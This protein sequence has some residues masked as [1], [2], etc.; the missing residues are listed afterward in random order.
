MTFN[1]EDIISK[2]QRSEIGSPY[3]IFVIFVIALC[4]WWKSTELENPSGL[5]I[6]G[7]KWYELGNGKARQRVRDDCL[8]IVRSSLQKVSNISIPTR[9][10]AT[11]ATLI[12]P[13]CEQYGDAFYLY[14]DS[15]YRLIL[16]GKYVDMLR[17]EKRLDFITALADVRNIGRRRE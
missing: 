14:T 8:G 17:N 2:Y 6:V 1:L 4:Y 11:W 15:R 3:P 12:T 10:L 16:S 13:I 5:P 7:R 9:S